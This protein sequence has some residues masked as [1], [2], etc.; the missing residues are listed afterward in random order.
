MRGEGWRVGCRDGR[1]VEG[2]GKRGGIKE[3]VLYVRTPM[4]R[5]IINFVILGEKR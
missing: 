1:E 3:I 5:I 4:H 2:G